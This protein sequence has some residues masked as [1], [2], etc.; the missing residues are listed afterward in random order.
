MGDGGCAALAAAG[1]W[2]Q[3]TRLELAY[4]GAGCRGVAAVAAAMTALRR[5]GLEACGVA[6]AAC[7]WVGFCGFK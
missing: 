2:P 4:S 6:D 7:R 3:L 5:L 1:G